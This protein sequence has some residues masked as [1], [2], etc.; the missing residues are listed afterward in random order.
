MIPTDFTKADLDSSAGARSWKQISPVFETVK[1][2]GFVISSLL[3]VGCGYGAIAHALA[4]YYGAQAHGLDIDRGR[5]EAAKS[6]ILAEYCDAEHDFFP[7][8]DDSMGMVVSIGAMEHMTFYDRMIGEVVRVLKEGGLFIVSTP[9]ASSWSTMYCLLRGYQSGDVEY[10]KDFRCGYHP[11]FSKGVVGHVHTWT[12]RSAKEYLE[13]KGFRHIMTVYHAPSD[14]D[15]KHK[16]LV[17]IADIIVPKMFARRF[18]LVMQ[19]K[20]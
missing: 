19:K 1:R 20:K 3:D 12:E 9:N 6:R 10:S 2:E 16:W 4:K 8:L 14:T 18:L 15:T 5:L 13:R 17:G 7:I 11:A